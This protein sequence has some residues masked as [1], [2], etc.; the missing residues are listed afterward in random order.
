MTEQPETHA[1]VHVPV[2]VRGYD[3]ILF[4]KCS[5]GEPGLPVANRWISDHWQGTWGD[6]AAALNAL[7]IE[8][9][10]NEEDA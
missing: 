1:A 3:G 8:A 4:V 7:V 6:G 2:E 10:V 5:C 9:R